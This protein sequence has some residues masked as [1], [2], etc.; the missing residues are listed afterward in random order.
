VLCC[1]CVACRLSL[2]SLPAGAYHLA[3]LPCDATSS[4]EQQQEQAEG[5][6]AEAG[7]R[8]MSCA[9]LLLQ[10]LLVLPAAAADELQQLWRKRCSQAAGMASGEGCGALL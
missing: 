5:I 10:P 6:S 9:P 7:S 8:H 3:L 4:K 1:C 2:P